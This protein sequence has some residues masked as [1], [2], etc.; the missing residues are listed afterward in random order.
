[1]FQNRNIW[2]KVNGKW[3]LGF[4]YSPKVTLIKKN[5]IPVIKVKIKIVL[6]KLHLT[7]KYCGSLFSVNSFLLVLI[8]VVWVQGGY[9]WRKNKNN[10]K[11]FSFEQGAI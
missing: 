10:R 1:M 6:L 4:K 3:E 9:N 2:L 7:A 11:Q 8:E 5:Y